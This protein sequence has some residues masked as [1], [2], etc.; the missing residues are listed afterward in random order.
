MHILVQREESRNEA[1]LGKLFINGQ[2][3]CDTL[4]DEIREQQGIPVAQ[5][6][7]YGKTAIPAG[8]YEVTLEP[9]PRFGPDTMTVNGVNGFDKIR[10][11]AGNTDEDTHGCL[12]VGVRN[13]DHTIGASRLTLSALK[14]RVLVDIQDGKTVLI[15]YKN[16][17]MEA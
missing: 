2:F 9:S 3:F 4:E 8:M 6:K 11:H 7:Q 10:I 16:P 17:I 15:E 5:W 1:T 12:L 14:Q 13:S